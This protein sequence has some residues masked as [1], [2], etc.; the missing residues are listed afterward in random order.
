MSLSFAMLAGLAAGMTIG[1]LLPAAAPW[2][3]PIGVLWFNALR[4]VVIPIV[5]AQLIL[6]IN[7][8][9]TER[10]VGTLGA[11]VFAWMV[12]L[13]LFCGT[14]TAFTTS[15]LFQFAP[16]GAPSGLKPPAPIAANFGD[17]FA[18]LLPSNLFQAAA[19]GKLIQLIFA[20]ILFG[21]AVRRLADDRRAAVLT[22]IEA[23]NEAM[24]T[25]IRW[26]LVIAPLGIGAMGCG[27][28]VKLGKTAVG[29]FAFYIVAF[30][31][32]VAF[33]VIFIYILVATR[34]K[35]WPW[36]KAIVPAQALAFG[37]L[38]SLGTLPLMIDIARD[39][40]KLP[41]PAVRFS[42]PLAVTLFR[43]STPAAQVGG[44]V[45]IA[46]LYNIPI[47]PMHIASLIPVSALLSLSAPGIPSSGLLVALPAFQQLGLP[48]E[49]LALL[50][51]ADAIPDMF[52]TSVNVTAHFAVA[53]ITSS[54]HSKVGGSAV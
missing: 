2:L 53:T 18:A 15:F 7:S 35:L 52:K 20:S 50:L 9:M 12:G 39:K 1:F 34:V 14:M 24:L 37:S 17:W 46:H 49:G 21:F 54:V 42:L 10:D 31:A 5:A 28:A 6:G 44:A 27:L 41:E 40:L 45:F 8:K 23:T 11:K 38:S 43:Y 19:E 47:T 32:A 26:A 30:S 3:E 51:A 29:A 22:V 25:I 4:M 16:A 36:A 13:L 33:N 48:P